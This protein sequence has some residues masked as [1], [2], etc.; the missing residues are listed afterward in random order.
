MFAAMVVARHGRNYLVLA[1]SGNRSLKSQ[2]C[3]AEYSD[4]YWYTVSHGHRANATTTRREK[5]LSTNPNTENL[6]HILPLFDR[7]KLLCH[8]LPKQKLASDHFTT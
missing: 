3:L 2:Q 6:S 8:N 1:S 5:G 7:P 4:L